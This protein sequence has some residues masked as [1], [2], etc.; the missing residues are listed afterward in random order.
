MQADPLAQLRDIRV[1]DPIGWWPL[2]PGWWFLMLLTVMFISAFIYKQ[3]QK[4]RQNRYRTL[5]RDELQIFKKRYDEDQD[6]QTFLIDTQKLLRRVALHR[7]SQDRGNFASLSG[8]AWLKYLNECCV[9]TV[10]ESRDTPLFESL[11]YQKN[12]R[13]DVNAWQ[14]SV[15]EWLEQ[16]R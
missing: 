8:A 13:F 16:H 7:Y 12:I 11:P 4:K 14:N 10:F 3:L 2:A 5:A 15:R 1:P 6:P 9:S